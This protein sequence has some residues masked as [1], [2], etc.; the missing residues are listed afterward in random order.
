MQALQTV[1][2]Q[3]ELICYLFKERLFC[4]VEARP[5]DLVGI[6]PKEL[7]ERYSSYFCWSNLMTRVSTSNPISFASECTIIFSVV[8]RE[9][10]T[11]VTES[12]MPEFEKLLSI[13]TYEKLQRKRKKIIRFIQDYRDKEKR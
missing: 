10:P 6:E 13:A 9:A 3:Q 1:H 11:V 8:N 7:E 4:Y 2:S 5:L 12:C